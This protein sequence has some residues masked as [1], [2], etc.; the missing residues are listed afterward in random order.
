MLV[1]VMFLLFILILSMMVAAPIIK[2]QIQHDREI[3]TMHRGKQYARAIKM[4]YKKFGAY[5]PNMDA[6]VN[7]NQIRFLRKKYT[8]P[9]TGKAD[10]KIIHVGQN[11][12]PT[13]WGFFGQPLTG[14]GAGGGCGVPGLSGS[15][16]SGTG[17]SGF[18]TGG[19]SS[20]GFG[21]SGTGSSGFGTSG[22]STSGFGGTST[23]GCTTTGSTDPSSTN[24]GQANS[25]QTN[26]GQIN[27]G[28]T[29]GPIDPN[30]P[31][32]PP[33]AIGGTAGGTTAANGTT[34]GAAGTGLDGQTGQTFGGAGIIGVSP[35]SPKQSI[36]TLH[37]KNHYNEWE[38]VYDPLA[39]QMMMQ[40]GNG[41]NGNPAGTS[42]PT[43]PFGTTP[44]PNPTNTTPPATPPVTTT[45]PS[46]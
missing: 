46:Q 4:Y 10:W 12:V 27:N 7:T 17:S 3:E 15:S 18:G 16:T 44:N 2:K 5:P 9:T 31:N 38:F 23:P 14:A 30:N 45:P 8:D 22:S 41:L 1:A 6:L 20:S 40:G 34:T 29:N 19:T 39:E 13:A 37:K 35:N 36:L 33:G 28:Q 25:G 32:S 43:S 26:N 42:N 24:N 11:K 21:S